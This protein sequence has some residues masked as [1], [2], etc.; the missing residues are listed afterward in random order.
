[1][2]KITKLFICTLIFL[3]FTVGL[4]NTCF[5]KIGLYDKEDHDYDIALL[6]TS[7]N[8]SDSNIYSV[9]EKITVE[10][11][12]NEQL[13]KVIPLIYDG[14]KK[15]VINVKVENTSGKYVIYKTVKKGNNLYVYFNNEKSDATETFK[16]SYEYNMGYDYDDSKDMFY[17]DLTGKSWTEDIKKVKFSITFPSF[18]DV[19]KMNIYSTTLDDD[20]L[21]ITCFAGKTLKGETTDIIPAL[22]NLIVTFKFD[23]GFF[24]ENRTL[25]DYL[26]DYATYV[27]VGLLALCLLILIK[28][29]IMI[30]HLNKYNP[31]IANINFEK[32]KKL[33]LNP[34]EI[35]YITNNGISTKDVVAMLYYWQE[36]D[37]ITIERV[38]R[39]YKITFNEIFIKGKDYEVKLY[40]YF[41]DFAQNRILY[42]SCIGSDFDGVFKGTMYKTVDS[43]IHNKRF[44]MFKYRKHGII[45]RYIALFLLSC[46]LGITAYKF[47]GTKASFYEGTFVSFI[48]INLLIKGVF[49]VL[50]RNI[51]NNSFLKGVNIIA[52]VLGI[53]VFIL[54]AKEMPNV[55]IYN[56]SR[57]DLLELLIVISIVI[58]ILILGLSFN[59]IPLSKNGKVIKNE[60]LTFKN[61]LENSKY[62]YTL[63]ELYYAIALDVE[64]LIMTNKDLLNYEFMQFNDQKLHINI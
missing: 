39:D 4:G 9:T 30:K 58:Y 25:V 12:D 45:L 59:S 31:E 19:R 51:K 23:D 17:F 26:P 27:I 3:S 10:H 18:F 21:C 11:Y 24:K 52:S 15:S 40:N 48:F 35:A 50:D 63:E 16:I 32:I 5:A 53:I 49:A 60:L 37:Y 42:L 29:K 7:I 13:C 54:L 28:D 44:F 14:I 22:N 6:D 1:M 33:K 64:P 61:M 38:H 57:F 41:Y 43:L 55:I 8:V 56:Y 34:M 2:K 62:E 47:M 36:K 46:V 20:N